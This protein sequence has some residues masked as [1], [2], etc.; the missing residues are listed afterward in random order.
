[1]RTGFNS[2]AATAWFAI[3]HDL[4]KRGSGLSKLAAPAAAK[5][6]VKPTVMT[7]RRVWFMR[8][9]REPVILVP[10]VYGHRPVHAGGCFFSQNKAG[11]SRGRAGTVRSCVPWAIH[12][13]DTAAK[14]P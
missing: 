9:Q 14:C 3:K 4:I 5:P 11:P 10:V 1:M 13:K 6:I 8:G 2:A 7:I 12:K